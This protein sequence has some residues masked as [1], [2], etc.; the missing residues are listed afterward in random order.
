MPDRAPLKQARS[1]LAEAR[2]NRDALLAQ[3]AVV[4]KQGQQLARTLPP[5]DERLTAFK[6]RERALNAQLSE[7]HAA[8][9]DAQA[10]LNQQIGS[11]LGQGGS[12]FVALNGDVPIALFP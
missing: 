12:D 2:A 8:V 1:A 10:G 4:A 5:N 6:E 9:R 3:A 11:F 7:S